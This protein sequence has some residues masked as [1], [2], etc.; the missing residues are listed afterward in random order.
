MRGSASSKG[1][2]TVIGVGVRNSVHLNEDRAERL[3]CNS[4][5]SFMYAGV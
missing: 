1:V 3:G 4:E 2:H 5:R